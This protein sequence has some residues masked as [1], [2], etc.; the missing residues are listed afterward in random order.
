MQ[1]TVSQTIWLERLFL[2]AGTDLK[3]KQARVL[4]EYTAEVDDEGKF[5]R[6][7]AV[8]I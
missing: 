8:Q 4:T 6:C 5:R 2:S 3:G 1:K 7:G